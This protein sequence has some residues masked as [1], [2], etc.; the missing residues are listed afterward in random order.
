MTLVAIGSEVE[1]SRD[2]YFRF[3]PGDLALP[4]PMGGEACSARMHGA[5]SSDDHGRLRAQCV[6]GG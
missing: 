6:S 1:M 3:E 2:Q 5:L 4:L